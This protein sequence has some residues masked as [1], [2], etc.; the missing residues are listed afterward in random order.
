MDQV[1]QAIAEIA[2]GR[3]VI[4]TDDPR[5]EDEGDLVAA[6]D[7]VA[8]ETVAFMATHGR[9]LVC[10]PISSERATRLD[11]PPMTAQNTESH[12]TAFTVSVDA[13]T[14]I[15]TGISA[16]DRAR[17]VR[18]LTDPEAGPDDLA[19]PGH[20][21]PLVA[22]PAGVLGRAGHTEAGV[23][24]ARLAGRTP[25]A[26]ICEM[27][28]PDGVPY[29]GEQ[30]RALARMHGLVRVSI[31]E[32]IQYRKVSAGERGVPPSSTA[33]TAQVL[34]RAARVRRGAAATLPTT[35]G[36]FRVL[37]FTDEDGTEHLALCTGLGADER[38][39]GEQDVLV[40]VHSE[41]L[42]GDVLGSQRCDC[43]QQLTGAQAAVAEHGR[44]VVLYLRGHE[45]RGIGL[46]AKI[47]AY[48]LQEQGRDTVQANLDQ[49][50]PVDAREYD[51]AAAILHDL[52]ADRVRL[53]SNNPAK[54]HALTSAGL[55]VQA[56]VPAPAPVGPEN[57]AYL[58]TKADRLG[59][60]LPWLPA[61]SA[62]PVPEE[63][64]R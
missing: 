55:T 63:G 42:T 32:L 38:F 14:G 41:C 6:A 25:A 22:H 1:S 47:H 19:R 21:F 13:A 23:D 51:T 36:L 28:T 44:G 57:L 30:L 50:L 34:A 56:L 45:G 8:P 15:T 7:A 4:V 54:A 24:L 2:A 60:L 9:G 61:P 29:R 37:P 20:V 59:H 18:L 58:R 40:R 17:T 27:L 39:A 46:A 43:G 52:G 16:A 12:G 33:R 31:A 53:I 10:A 35:T 11:L 5:R 62:P 64:P 26:V 3:M 49:G 48:A